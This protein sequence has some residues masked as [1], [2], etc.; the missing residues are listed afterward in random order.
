M[1]LF[2]EGVVVVDRAPWEQEEIDQWKGE[3]TKV[4][5]AEETRPTDLS[6][7][8]LRTHVS[9]APTASSIAP[10][11]EPPR[12]TLPPQPLK[13]QA[14]RKS[15]RQEPGVGLQWVR[16]SALSIVILVALA[17]FGIVFYSNCSIFVV[18]P[19][20]A[21]PNGATLIT[22]RL[23][24]LNFIDSAEGFLTRHQGTVTPSARTAMADH[25]AE[26]ARIYM[27]LPYF[28][29]LHRFTTRGK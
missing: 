20:D 18:A 3:V 28:G 4:P 26:S 19:T 7:E 6:G 23:S 17:A 2:S 21:H 14:E 9:R 24:G 12:P 11:Y 29:R 13:T 8:K 15:Q 5:D 1:L 16:D 25:I 22:N 10:N 27:E